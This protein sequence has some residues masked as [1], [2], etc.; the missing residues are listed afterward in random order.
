VVFSFDGKE[1]QVEAHVGTPPSF[2]DYMER[3]RP[4]K[5]RA[6]AMRRSPAKS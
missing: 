6:C 2:A 4:I 1:F 5:P 3:T